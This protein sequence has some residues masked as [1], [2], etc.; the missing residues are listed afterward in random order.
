MKSKP[1]SIVSTFSSLSST[2]I[3]SKLTISC[4]QAFLSC[5]TTG[6][7]AH[8]FG[9]NLIAMLTLHTSFTHIPHFSPFFVHFFSNQNL[10]NCF[11]CEYQS[12]YIYR[13]HFSTPAILCLSLW[14]GVKP[15]YEADCMATSDRNFQN[16]S[17]KCGRSAFLT[18][19]VKHHRG[20][21]GLNG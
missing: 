16:S 7:E 12:V 8:M 20:N 1:T 11:S 4:T 17:T 10:R 18:F 19:Y 13:D 15:R 6:P 3:K 2:P 5:S 21:S 14:N 9:Y